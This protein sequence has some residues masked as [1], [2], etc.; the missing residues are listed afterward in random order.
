MFTEVGLSLIRQSKEYELDKFYD[1]YMGNFGF[2]EN[3]LFENMNKILMWLEDHKDYA[4]IYQFC[5]DYD[6][7]YW[8]LTPQE[9]L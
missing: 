7:R 8:W 1:A 4:L 5:E 3:D 9:L 2:T 6:G